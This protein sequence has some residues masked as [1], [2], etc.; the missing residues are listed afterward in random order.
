MDCTGSMGS[1]IQAAKKNIEAI[2]AKLV[3]SE[4]YDLR[5][6]LVAYRDHPPQDMS[7]VTKKFAFTN[8]VEQMKRDLATLSAKGGGDGPE[9]VAAGLK[10]TLES[11]W[12]PNAT[13]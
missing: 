7:Y 8:S 6:A 11:E 3:Q 12:R 10:A 9:A 1:Y 13:K 2:A 4:G 5:F